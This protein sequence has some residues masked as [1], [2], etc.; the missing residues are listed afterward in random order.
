MYIS[1]L[2][3]CSIHLGLRSERVVNMTGCRGL[4]LV[5]QLVEWAIA[6]CPV[7]ALKIKERNFPMASIV[8]FFLSVK[9]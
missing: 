1:F 3:F 6:L 4:C 7:L 8:V 5:T 2:F 9:F